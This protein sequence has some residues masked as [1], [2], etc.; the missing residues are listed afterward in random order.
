MVAPRASR[1]PPDSALELN[2]VWARV[3]IQV[4]I[5]GNQAVAIKDHIRKCAGACRAR[6]TC[7][8]QI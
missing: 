8:D 2:Q 5:Y 3:S 7:E 1:E 4:L 6:F